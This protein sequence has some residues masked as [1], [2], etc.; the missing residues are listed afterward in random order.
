MSVSE[1]TDY[2]I[3]FVNSLQSSVNCPLLPEETLSQLEKISII[4]KK[5]LKDIEKKSWRNKKI[6]KENN[7]ER[8]INSLL[9]KINTKNYNQIK[10]QILEKNKEESII[11]S[12]INNIFTKAIS[13]PCF[14]N[15]YIQLYKELLTL[16]NNN[17]VSHI[18]IDKCDN[19]LEIFDKKVE[20]NDQQEGSNYEEICKIYKQK[21]Y[22]KGYSQFIGDLYINQIIN[23]Q[24]IDEFINS[25]FKN[26]NIIK[27]NI[28]LN[29][30]M[31]E[32]LDSLHTLIECIGGDFNKLEN[33][34][35]KKNMILEFSRDKQLKSKI[36]FKF[37]DICDL[38][39]KFN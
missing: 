2:T 18:I 8:D 23:I 31:E 10:T 39:K 11:I 32:Y 38:L 9:N 20:N 27:Y 37:M 1:K 36:K 5:Y 3:D 28:E 15:L 14:C 35:N 21:D 24:K 26:M 16:N 6:V 17:S 19:Y 4:L 34:E 22:I 25:I 33:F 29:S 7:V 12:T 13:Q 30:T